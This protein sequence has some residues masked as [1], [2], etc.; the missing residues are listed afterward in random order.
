MTKMSGAAVL[1]TVL[2]QA[3]ISVISGIPGH[4]IGDFALAVGANPAFTCVLPRHES[5]AA[6]AADVY[7]RVSGRLMAAFTHAFP[8]AGNALTAVANAYADYSSLF[9]IAG[10]TASPAIGRGGYQELSRQINDDL[11]QLIRPTVKRI[12]Q[13][14]TASDIASNALAALREA[15]SGRPGPVA[16]NVSQEIWAQEVDAPSALALKKFTFDVRP[17]PDSASVERA[18][19]LLA[20]AE[21][22]L[23]LVG[24]GVNMGRARSQLRA[25]AELLRIP[26]AT[27]ASGKGSFPEN[28]PLSVGVAGWTG[29]ATANEATRSADVILVLGAR[30]SETTSSSWVPNA[31]F[32]AQTRIIQAD[33][34]VAGISNAYP[35][36]EVLVGDLRATLDDLGV[37][38]KGR[39]GGDLSAWHEHLNQ[40]RSSW[41][42]TAAA[43]Q[44]LGS[45]GAIGTGAVV[46]ALRK[47]VDRPINLVNDC[48]KHHKWIVQQFEARED[49]YIISSMGGAAMGLGLA[50]AIGA[51]LARPEGK[52]VAWV[53]DG[54]L[55][56]S[57]AALPTVAEYRL[58]IITVVIDD[59]AYGVVRNTQMAQVGRV[60]FSV[61]DGSGT[62]PDYRLDFTAVA[63]GCGIPGRTVA[64]PAE[65]DAAF[66]WA[67]E[68]EG[69]CLLTILSDIESVHPAGG[70]VLRTLDDRSRSLVWAPSSTN[71]AHVNDT[72]VAAT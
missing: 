31:T 70:G 8:G 64:N 11:T 15:R 10:N 48:G 35:V 57:L 3:G 49:D 50:G 60:A 52:T 34:D 61:F 20:G 37:V 42:K 39:K 24:N 6:F 5:T 36:D 7:F 26:V 33:I 30:L 9:F 23:I 59:A 72:A 51:A 19:R 62:N 25:L 14:R 41:A 1:A 53:G 47:A 44:A 32:S 22:P 18:A 17:R 38:M 71:A 4:T 46:Q 21:R 28:H 12:W 29:T 68:Q 43:S 2:E 40:A 13:P 55:A 45:A 56:M 63:Q 27:T 65:L 16:L 54:G 58:P 67:E 66:A 69:P